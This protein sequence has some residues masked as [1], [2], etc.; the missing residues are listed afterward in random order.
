MFISRGLVY[1]EKAE[2]ML[3]SLFLVTMIILAVYQI[4]LRWFTSGGL[5][6]ID[7]LLRY[8]VLWSGL[9]GAVYATSQDK[10]IAI[11][12][13]DF[14]LPET[15]GKWLSFVTSCFSTIV[16]GLLC[17]ASLLF[18]QSEIEFGGTGLFNLPSWTWGLIFPL[19]FALICFHFT[20]HSVL[21]TQQVLGQ[22]S[23]QVQ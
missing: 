22:R 21:L 5:V 12:I 6:W 3:L 16:A 20:I 19:S 15:A 4:L 14:V 9:L 13:S 1:I 18:I 10:H 8:L 23:S 17:R 2:R 11:N 7:P